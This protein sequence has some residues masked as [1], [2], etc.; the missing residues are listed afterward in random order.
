MQELN[1]IE[2][3]VLQWRHFWSVACFNH[4][5]PLCFDSSFTAMALTAILGSGLHWYIVV[6]TLSSIRLFSR[7][8]IS[9][10]ID[11]YSSIGVGESTLICINV[12]PC[13]IGDKCLPSFVVSSCSKLILVVGCGNGL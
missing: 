10:T 11:G 13:S 1:I 8:R 7:Y 5:S 6:V 9:F 3:L 2:A 12:S 4:D